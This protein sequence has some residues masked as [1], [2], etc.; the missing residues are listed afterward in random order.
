MRCC[1]TAQPLGVVSEYKPPAAGL[2]ENRHNK[3]DEYLVHVSAF[4]FL[5]LTDHRSMI[6]D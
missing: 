4:R 6:N 1:E 2:A 3:S 5:F